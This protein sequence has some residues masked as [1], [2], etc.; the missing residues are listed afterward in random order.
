M[1]RMWPLKS[2]CGLSLLAAVLLILPISQ[3]GAQDDD[4]PSFSLS[5]DFLNSYVFRGIAYSD[6]SLVIQPSMTISYKGFSANLWGNFDTNESERFGDLRG[7]A[8]WNETDLTLSYSQELFHG[9]TGTLGGVYYSLIGDDS[10]EVFAGLSYPLPWVTLGL[11]TYRE[12]S[13]FPGWWVQLDLSRNIALTCYGM[14]VDLGATFGFLESEDDGNEFSGLLSGQLL[15]TLN[16]PIGKHF[17]ISPRIGYAFPLSGRAGN[18]IE[19]LSWD[20]EDDR[21]FGGIRLSASF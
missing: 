12:I 13:H 14:S 19:S 18:R 17:A 16:V 2:G 15:A 8:N 3:V 1:R 20:G 9:L 5:A 11:T 10:F 7:N 21:V 4:K 6:E